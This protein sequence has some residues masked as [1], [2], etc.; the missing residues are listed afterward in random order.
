MQPM[1]ASELRALALRL[2]KALDDAHRLGRLHLALSTQR[3]VLPKGT[4]VDYGAAY[5]IAFAAPEQ[6]WHSSAVG[7]WTDVYSLGLVLLAL[8]TR[9]APQSST[10]IVGAIEARKQARD[11]SVLPTDMRV[12]VG[13]MI[14]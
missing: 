13:R 4:V 12:V 14:E 8:A 9:G 6:V 7:P 2:A 3:I 1:D 10:T 5:D 11:L